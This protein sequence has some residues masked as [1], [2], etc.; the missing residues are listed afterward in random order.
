MITWGFVPSYSDAVTNN[1]LFTVNGL[2]LLATYIYVGGA[3]GDIV[4]E[5]NQGNA[6]WLPGALLGQS[7]ILGARRIL[8]TG[9][10]NGTS[11]TTTATG[12]VWLAVNQLYNAP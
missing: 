9:T 4:W 11:R 10:V 8:S 1:S 7:Y 12:L 5:N 3:S 2:T 6:Q